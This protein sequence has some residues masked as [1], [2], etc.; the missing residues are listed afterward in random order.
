MKTMYNAAG[1]NTS[2]L[3][4]SRPVGVGTLHTAGSLGGNMVVSEQG[5]TVPKLVR[6]TLTICFPFFVSFQRWFFLK[7]IIIFP[8]NNH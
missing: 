4:S 1:K 8:L 6:H 5:G 7:L 3:C 2:T